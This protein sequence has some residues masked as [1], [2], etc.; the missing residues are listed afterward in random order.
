MT[1]T[2]NPEIRTGRQPPARASAVDIM[3]WPARASVTLAVTRIAALLGLMVILLAMAPVRAV[4]RQGFPRWIVERWHAG[5]CRIA[6]ITPHIRGEKVTDRPVLFVA[7]HV[8][9][10]DISILGATLD[11]SFVAKSE[12]QG[13]PVFGYLAE[14]QRTVFVARQGRHVDS[15]RQALKERLAAGDSLILF[16]EGTSSDGTRALRFKS[17]LFDAASIE[18]ESGQVEVQPISIAYT[19]FDGMP[20]GRMLRP[21]YAWYG[22]MDLAPH[23]FRALGMGTIEVD[24]VFHPPVRLADFGSRKALAR[25]C[26]TV[27]SRGLSSALAGRHERP[28]RRHRLRLD[29]FD[30]PRAAETARHPARKPA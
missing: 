19:R 7:N 17:A 9:Y 14:L 16:P 20:M 1:K 5:C 27:V 24:V 26:E 25:H 13:W 2:Q 4:R 10:L 3:A 15:Q 18:L 28:Q 8:S 12:V 29:A 11:A 30:L 22:D 21:F 6:G 23:L